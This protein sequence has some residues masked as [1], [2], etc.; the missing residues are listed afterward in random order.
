[1]SANVLTVPECIPKRDT[2]IVLEDPSEYR[3]EH[4]DV[5]DFREFSIHT[6]PQRVINT[7]KMMHTYQTLDYVK[8][9]MEHWGKYMYIV[10]GGGV[11]SG[12][13]V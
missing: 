9:K 13:H 6:S 1:M 12:G 7:Y 4:K 3:P 5:K 11:E 2:P 10:G 8:G